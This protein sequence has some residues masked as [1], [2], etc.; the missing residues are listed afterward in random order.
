MIGGRGEEPMKKSYIGM[1]WIQIQIQI[2]KLFSGDKYFP[3][4]EY[5]YVFDV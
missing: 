3:A 4:G 2:I 5:D 1:F